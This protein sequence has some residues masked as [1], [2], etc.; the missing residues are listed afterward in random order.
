MKVNTHL[1]NTDE[2]TINNM[3]FLSIKISFS[4]L[5]DERAYILI[6]RPNRHLG[7]TK[8]KYILTIFL[9]ISNQ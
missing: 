5:Y 8:Q 3:H 4:D 2:D 6:Y 9:V 7:T 1:Y